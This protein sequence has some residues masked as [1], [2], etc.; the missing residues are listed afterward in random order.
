MIVSFRGKSTT[1][2]HSVFSC[3][4]AYDFSNSDKNNFNVSV[5]YNSS[6][7]SGDDDVGEVLSGAGSDSK[8]LRLPRAVNLV[9]T[10]THTHKR[11]VWL[12]WF[13]SLTS[14]FC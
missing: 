10:V 6:L 13:L 9:Y 5:W 11:I 8:L 12:F 2:T 14:L 4:A 3:N 7:K 1:D